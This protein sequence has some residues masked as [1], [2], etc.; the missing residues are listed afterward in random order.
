[1]LGLGEISEGG[2]K[3]GKRMRSRR[4]RRRKKR[5]SRRWRNNFLSISPGNELLMI[6]KVGIGAVL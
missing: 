5:T 2:A 4:M 6:S 1:M 3:G